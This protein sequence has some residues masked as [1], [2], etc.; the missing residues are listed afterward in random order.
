M[1]S[2]CLVLGG[3]SKNS[4]PL[5]VDDYDSEPIGNYATSNTTMGLVV[6]GRNNTGGCDRPGCNSFICDR[7]PGFRI[8]D[9][10][11][12]EQRFY[13]TNNCTYQVDFGSCQYHCHPCGNSGTLVVCLGQPL[14]KDLIGSFKT[15]SPT[16][17]LSLLVVTEKPTTPPSSTN[18]PISVPFSSFLPTVSPTTM[19]TSISMKVDTEMTI[20]TIVLLVDENDELRCNNATNLCDRRVDEIVFATVHNAA[21]T[22]ANGFT[23]LPNH[24]RNLTE[25]LYAGYR[26]INV[27]IGLCNNGMLGLVHSSCYLGFANLTTTLQEIADFLLQHQREVLLMPTQLDF[28]TGGDF[29]LRQLE[30]V[31]PESFRNLLYE[32]PKDGRPWPLLREL[33]DSNQRILFFHYNGKRC[34]VSSMN[35]CPYGFMDW[36]DYA[37]ESE[38]S[39]PDI[40]ALQD[41]DNACRITRGDPNSTSFYGINVF[42]SLPDP[43]VC[44]ALNNAE[45]LRHHMEACSNIT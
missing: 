41:K 44:A 25:A 9:K 31:M 24:Q 23:I 16:G 20:P 12:D 10:S 35:N 18:R 28:D 29:S 8:L 45:F 7:K 39:L 37:A 1:K 22:V 17:A 36:F 19:P 32:H 42:T 6:D 21:S 13:L 40:N 4:T 33:I 30:A 38:F 11:F 34:D 43:N 3:S 26:G 5:T 27:D 2:F 15:D 14:C